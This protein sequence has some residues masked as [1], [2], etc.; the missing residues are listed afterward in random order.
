MLLGPEIELRAAL[1]RLAGLQLGQGRS[2]RDLGQLNR[3]GLIRLGL[4]QLGLHQL[5]AWASRNQR[6]QVPLALERYPLAIAGAI[7]D[8]RQDFA[9]H[10]TLSHLDDSNGMLPL[11]L[12]RNVLGW[13][14]RRSPRA[15]DLGALGHGV[16]ILDLDVLLDHIVVGPEAKRLGNAQPKSVLAHHSEL[17]LGPLFTQLDRVCGQNECERTRRLACPHDF[18]PA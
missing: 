1:P 12:L 13:L 18:E 5:E 9:L 8:L 11:K 2:Q 16:A 4:A 14:D 17:G 15:Q 6:S 3:L 7:P 10:R